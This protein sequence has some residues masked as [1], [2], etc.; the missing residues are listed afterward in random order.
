MSKRVR[1][2]LLFPLIA[3]IFILGWILIVIG[4]RKTTEPRRKTKS[5]N[6]KKEKTK[7]GYLEMGIIVRE[8]TEE[9]QIC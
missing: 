5:E 4:D 2:I 6:P 1:A 7:K 3:F 8:E 9:E